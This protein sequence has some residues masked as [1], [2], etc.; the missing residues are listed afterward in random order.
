MKPGADPLSNLTKEQIQLLRQIV[1]VYKSGIVSEFRLVGNVSG[2]SALGYDGSRGR[3]GH[4]V[5]IFA[6][7][8]DFYQLRDERLITLRRDFQ[9]TLRGL[10]TAAGIRAIEESDTTATNAAA[11]GDDGSTISRSSPSDTG[12]HTA[13]TAG[14]PVNPSTVPPAPPVPDLERL[15]QDKESVNIPT[16]AR[17][18]GRSTGHVGRLVRGGKLDR[19]GQVRPTMVATESL[20]K[21]KGT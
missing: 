8:S 1:G 2:H 16:A 17:Y 6:S 14:P 7:D 5:E 12:E 13:G 21:Y 19:V 15:I 11:T 18:L 4:S 10:P 20:R 9:G 3:R